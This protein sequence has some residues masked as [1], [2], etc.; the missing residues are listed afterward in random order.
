MKNR[1]AKALYIEGSRPG[2]EAE[3]LRKA[4]Q[5]IDRSVPYTGLTLN[6]AFPTHTILSSCHP[7]APNWL[8][9][10][11]TPSASGRS[12]HSWLL[13]CVCAG[14]HVPVR[15][16]THTHAYTGLPEGPGPP[17]SVLT[18]TLHTYPTLGCSLLYLLLCSGEP[19]HVSEGKKLPEHMLFI[20]VSIHSPMAPRS[21]QA[22]GM[23]H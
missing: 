14:A 13:T 19:L 21:V 10:D 16:R 11:I 4:G 3:S 15:A 1:S 23:S 5:R 2:S 6:L 12:Q 22:S 8:G 20:Y 9:Q 18:H 17:S 7:P